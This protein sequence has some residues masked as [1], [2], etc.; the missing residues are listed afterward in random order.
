[1]QLPA[2][3][4]QAAHDQRVTL[5][6][7]RPTAAHHIASLATHVMSPDQNW[8]GLIPSPAEPMQRAPRHAAQTARPYLAQSPVDALPSAQFGPNIPP[9]RLPASHPHA[10]NRP[11]D[12]P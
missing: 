11:V 4:Q 2:F 1:M 9:N 3:P 12:R 8:E 5:P 7:V 6:P 10:V